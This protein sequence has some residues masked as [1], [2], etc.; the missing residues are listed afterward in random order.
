MKTNQLPLAALALSALAV[1]AAAGTASD[2]HLL[3]SGKSVKWGAPPPILPPG[4]T[5]AVI[6]GDPAG[7]GLVTV[8][9]KMPAGY[10]I[11]PHWHPTDEHVTVLTGSLG[12]GMGDT[13]DPAHGQTLK[14]GGYAVAPATMHHYAWTTTG[15]TIQVHLEGPFALTYV[16]PADDPSKSAKP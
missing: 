16:N 13:L 8:R 10:K 11:P 15:A 3:D 12:I 2:H 7:K 14:A 1:A 4:A 9:L 5:F 6:D